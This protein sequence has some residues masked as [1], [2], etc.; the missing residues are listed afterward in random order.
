MP[1]VVTSRFGAYFSFQILFSKKTE[2]KTVSVYLFSVD[3]M[4]R[5]VERQREGGGRG[6]ERST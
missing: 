2:E 5:E 4:G 3:E 1:Q 6:R